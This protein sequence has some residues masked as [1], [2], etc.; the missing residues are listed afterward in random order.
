MAQ[1]RHQ[2]GFNKKGDPD[3]IFCLRGRH[4]EFEVK[5]PKNKSTPLQLQRQKLWKECGAI[6]GQVR[7]VDDVIKVL[8][9][10][11]VRL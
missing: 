3:I 2:A 10:H 9:E 7:D 11:G 4:G 5:R 8:E 6:V 1:V